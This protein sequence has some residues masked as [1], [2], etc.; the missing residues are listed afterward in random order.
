M[1]PDSYRYTANMDLRLVND[2]HILAVG[3]VPARSR[4]LDLGAA[5]GSV[6]SV[7]KAMGCR[8]WGVEMD[9]EAAETARLHCEE[10]V[11]GDLEDPATLDGLEGHQFDVVLMLDVLE[12]LSDP[13]RVLGTVGR[14][15]GPGGWGVI[16][17]P[18]VAHI[19]LRLELME[20]RFTYRDAGLLDRTHLRFFDRPGVDQLMED[21]GWAVFGLERVTRRLGDTEID[22]ED[23]DVDL[24]Q[25][26]SADPEAYTYQ[27]VLSAA[28]QG[29]SVHDSPPV[30]PAAVA[31]RVA[32]EVTAWAEHLQSLLD[33]GVPDLAHQLQE[34]RRSSLDRRRQLTD[35]ILGMKEDT[36]RLR[37]SLS[38]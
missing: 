4:V 3:R 5:D 11:V 7:L 32:L 18:N 2:A 15:L 17:L 19:S 10:V 8:V 13:A 27:F 28:P 6:A 23:P 14:L 20:G 1:S 22:F 30:L 36:E 21:A 25:R 9:P 26:I 31:Q 37:R 33:H 29:S 35:L 34:I 12:H 16:S 38:G 24:V